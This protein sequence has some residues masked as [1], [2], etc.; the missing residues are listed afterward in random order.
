LSG[1][2]LVGYWPGHNLRSKTDLKYVF[3]PCPNEKIR[4]I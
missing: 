1:F 2:S 3:L 4:K